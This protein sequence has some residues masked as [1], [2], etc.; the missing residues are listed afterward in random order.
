MQIRHQIRDLADRQLV[1]EARHLGASHLDDVDHTLI[2]RRDSAGHELFLEQP[3][4]AWPAQ[5]TRAIRIVT[6]GAARVIYATP[7]RLLWS[8]AEFS[9]G[10]ARLSLAS[11]HRD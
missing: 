10:F 5:I 4:Q 1:L 8:E 9:V 3:M 6:F 7:P 2:I 11:K